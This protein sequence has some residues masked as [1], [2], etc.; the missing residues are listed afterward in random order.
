M[1][2]INHDDLTHYFIKPHSELPVSYVKSCKK[3]MTTYSVAAQIYIR[4]PKREWRKT[5]KDFEENGYPWL[6]RKKGRV[7]P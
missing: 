3:F 6:K 4:T 7:G 2:R 1:K 5:R